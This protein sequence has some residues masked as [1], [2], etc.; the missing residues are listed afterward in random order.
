MKANLESILQ[1]KSNNNV[2]YS[3]FLQN[4]W[5]DLQSDDTAR[6]LRSQIIAEMFQADK[7]FL[8]EESSSAPPTIFFSYPIFQ[9]FPH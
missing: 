5:Q 4:I 9:K 7:D 8:E 2:F 6:T 3:R 1:E